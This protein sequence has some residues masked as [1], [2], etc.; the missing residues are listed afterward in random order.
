MSGECT[1]T[2]YVSEAT[3]D[4][5]LKVVESWNAKRTDHVKRFPSAASAVN[6]ATIDEVLNALCTWELEP[7]PTR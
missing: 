6:E 5:V 2:I 7:D 3:L 4:L 1:A